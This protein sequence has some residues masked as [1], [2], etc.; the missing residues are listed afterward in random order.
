MDRYEATIGSDAYQFSPLHKGSLGMV[1]MY[2]VI[3]NPDAARAGNWGRHFYRLVIWPEGRPDEVVLIHNGRGDM[4]GAGRVL[5]EFFW[6]G[7]DQYGNLVPAGTYE[8]CFRARFLPM[9]DQRIHSLQSYADLDAIEA[10]EEAQESVETV[11]VN[12]DLDPSMAQHL[13]LMRAA[14]ACQIQTNTPLESGF[15]Y[16]FYY[17][18][19]H[20][21]SNLSDGGL[22]AATSSTCKSGQDGYGVWGPAE[23]YAYA[24]NEAGCDFWI[25]T[26]HN[27]QFDDSVNHKNPPLTEAK[28]KQA[29]QAGL[30]AAQAATVNG[31]FVALFG[32]EWGTLATN[33]GHINIYESPKL[34]GW[35]TCSSCTGSNAECTPGSNCYFD[36]FTPKNIHLPLYAR[37]VENPSPAGS[38]GHFCHPSS[39][40]FTSF[41]FDANADNA[42]QGIAIRSG[43]AFSVG[44]FTCADSNIGSSVYF[45]RWAEALNKGFHLGPVMDQDSHCNNHGVAV[46]N[47]TCYVVPNGTS[48]ALTRANI[49]AAHRAR[50]FFATEDPNIQLV[51]TAG[52]G[53]IM[54]DIFTAPAGLSF[55][56][57]AY[58]PD[59]ETFT[60]VKVFRGQIGGGA[61]SSSSPWQSVTNQSTY[62]FSDTVSSGTYY[63]FVQVTQSD[64]HDAWSA[65]MWVT[66]SGSTTYTIQGSCG[67]SGATVTA[68]SYTA[69]SDASGNYTLSS[70]PAGTYTV[71]VSK[72]GCTFSPTSLSVTVGPNATGKNFTADC[73]T[74]YSIAGNCG[75]A[76]A[77]VTAGTKSA[78]SDG[79]GNYTLSNL[80]AGTYTVSASKSGCTFSP[81]SLSVTVGPNATGKN[82][83][84]SCGTTYYS[85]AGNCGTASATVT[86]GSASTTAD[87]S[88]NYT[89]SNLTAGTYTVSAS[90]S[91]CTF[92]PTSLSVTVGPN[93][94]GKNFTATCGSGDTQLTSGTTL[95]SQSV[96][97]SA[98]KYYYITVPSGATS[99]EFK[100]TNAS[101][102]IDIYT[103]AGSKPDLSNYTCRPY[104]GSGNET[105]TATNPAAGT[106]YLGV[107]G[108]KAATFS[109]TAT[110][111][112][113]GTTYYSIAGSCGT[114]SA[115]VTAGSYSA[116]SDASGNYTISNLPAGTYTVTPSK[117]GCT[118]S[119]TSTSVTV[120]PN[121][122]GKNFTASCG[123][124]T[125]ALTSGSTLTGQSVALQAWKYYT[126]AVPSG[127]TGL[128]VATSGAS[129]DIDLYVK[130]NAQPTGSVYDCAK[131]TSSG[132]E[133]CT[134]SSPST[135]TYYIGVY[136]YAAASYAITATVTGGTGLT[137]RLANG[138]F[139]TITASCATAPDGSWARSAYT[140]TA[141]NILVTGSSYY[142]RTGSD[143]AYL[144]VYNSSTQT[145]DS[146]AITI[147]STAT[148]ATLSFYVSVVTAETGTTA[149]DKLEVQLVNTS[150][151]VLATLGTVTNLDK[152]SSA[153][154]YV[155]KSYS[156]L[157][158]KGQTVKVRFK[159]TNGSSYVTTFRVDDVSLMSN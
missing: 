15:G 18:S 3:V 6:D 134:I 96:A 23:I 73:T 86:A 85:I 125:T 13:R 27:H 8:F 46:P 114:A 30:A 35:D 101:A 133:T 150:G 149:Y 141:F 36:V 115:T 33:G 14:G 87:G 53:K 28:V 147:P 20:S 45:T 16:N 118:F 40:D 111:V 12:Y 4:D 82:F 135:G 142:P 95:N 152:T 107:Y 37:M 55:R 127:S 7:R 92:S 117:S 19:N 128:T 47:R 139:E 67:T 89:I 146:A 129:A 68:G 154:T 136:G 97:L 10:K 9:L 104:S 158:Y 100:T 51:F 144:G 79:S 126:I 124:G 49:M 84:A 119:P 153:S 94:T 122:T 71:S 38:I 69:T 123:S 98:W 78:T 103:R 106:W 59:G 151:T 113:G 112:A 52:N 26:D 58:D 138:G 65:P 54:G 155:Q 145:L 21:H 2:S 140:G 99:L 34:F 77:T 70:L 64:G 93:A 91:G 83:T 72:S 108:Y 102:D 22:D 80:T 63:Y 25:I 121:A 50:H 137:E 61:V 116:T 148:Q 31:S 32:Q 132:N 60:A 110:V 105:C 81:T 41:T 157:S 88:G 159:A 109:V 90:K 57:A 143:L 42:L 5:A 29:Y 120:G 39:G 48:P 74:Y 17:G 24:R 156:V 131:E 44:A 62:T 75:T 11:V 130:F 76:S 66:Y 56:V 43:L 1:R